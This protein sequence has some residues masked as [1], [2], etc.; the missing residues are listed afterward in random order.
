MTAVG[1]YFREVRRWWPRRAEAL[2]PGQRELDAFPRFADN[3]LRPPPAR[4]EPI[5]RIVSAALGE[6]R[7][8]LDE[9]HSSALT[10]S[11]MSDFHCVTTWTAR[12]QTW[13]GVPLASWWRT[14]F[15]SL[16]TDSSAFAVVRAADGYQAVFQIDDLFGD[17]VMLA[18]GLNGG[19]LDQRHGFPLRLVSPSQYG[20]KSVKHVEA[21]ELC[22]ERPASRLGRKEHLR[23]RVLFEERHSRIPGRV[24]RWPYRLVVPVTAIVAERTLARSDRSDTV[25]R[26]RRPRAP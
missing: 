24:L 5:V 23:A 11:E 17:D 8:L 21:I 20:Y 1:R 2:P 10:K 22:A 13:T 25:L 18:W 4:N 3:P 14:R 26:Q 19:P 12:R 9:L 15:G 16:P 6:T 7:I